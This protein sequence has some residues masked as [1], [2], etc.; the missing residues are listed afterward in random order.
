MAEEVVVYSL[1][2]CPTCK[3]AKDFLDK[4]G[5]KYTNYDVGKDKAKA[6]EMLE[7]S[8]GGRSVPV[9]VICGDAYIGFD[10]EKLEKALAC[11]DKS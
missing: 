7:I 8:E 9:V 10:S 1:D 6:K 2:T 5:V 11:L 3:K 4:K